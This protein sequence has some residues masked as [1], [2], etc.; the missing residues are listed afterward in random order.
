MEGY[1]GS[2][3]EATHKLPRATRAESPSSLI[4]LA[5]PIDATISAGGVSRVETQVDVGCT[6]IVADNPRWKGY[7]PFSYF[8]VKV[9]RKRGG[10][11]DGSTDAKVQCTAAH[12]GMEKEWR[13]NGWIAARS[14]YRLGSLLGE[15]IGAN[16][17]SG[18]NGKR[19]A[20]WWSAEHRWY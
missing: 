4:S 7:K 14:L 19:V 12:I 13:R 20:V 3:P 8:A 1:K 5:S 11:N 16:G 9:L 10:E 15:V 17:H 6:C 18:L 2:Q